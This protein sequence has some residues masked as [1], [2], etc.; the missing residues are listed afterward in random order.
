MSEFEI[1]DSGERET[2]GSGMVRDTEDGKTD[3]TGLVFGPMLRRWAEHSTKGRAKYPDVAPG[4]PN[5][6]L[7]DSPEELQRARRSAARHFFL[8]L[9]GIED[10]DHAAG[11]FF[12]INEAENIKALLRET[13]TK[14]G[15]PETYEVG[16]IVSAAGIANLRARGVISGRTAS[17]LGMKLP[18]RS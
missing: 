11:V 12:N 14:W 17:A 15:P 5:W 8:W 16:S 4:V 1:K 2:F 13:Q 9:E 18:W 6:T 10:E 3:F 7:A